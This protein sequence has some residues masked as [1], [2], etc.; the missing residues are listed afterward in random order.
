MAPKIRF[1]CYLLLITSKIYSQIPSGPGTPPSIPLVCTGGMLYRIATVEEDTIAAQTYYN[2]V[3]APAV[4][5][6]PTSG[7]VTYLTPSVFNITTS[8]VGVKMVNIGSK[9]Y[10]ANDNALYCYNTTTA[11][12]V[13]TYTPPSGYEIVDFSFKNDT[14]CILSQDQ[15]GPPPVCPNVDLV[16]KLN[17]S[18]IAQNLLNICLSGV[19]NY[20]L[21]A[22][23]T[24]A[25]VNNKLV[26]GGRFQAYNTSGLIDSNLVSFNLNTNL[27]Q[28]LNLKINDTV[29]EVE[30]KINQVHLVG[31]FTK[32]G[33][34]TRNH[35]AVLSNSLTL[36]AAPATSFVGDVDQIEFYDK[37]LFALGK[38]SQINSTV[39]NATPNYTIGAVNL[40]TNTVKN[41][42]INPPGG[43][44]T[45]SYLLKVIQNKL[46]V[47]C[48]RAGNTYARYFLPPRMAST[49]ISAATTS[50]CLPSSNN[51][52]SISPALYADSYSW[53]YS[54]TGVTLTFTN[55]IAKINFLTSATSGVLSVYAQ[56]TLGGI[57]DVLTLSL[58]A[59]PVPNITAS[60]PTQ[61][62]TCYNPKV[63]ILSSSTTTNVSFSWAG[64]SGYTSSNQN[65]S[66]GYN[67]PGKYV[68][69]V[70]NN[71]TGCK[72]R[73][74]VNVSIDTLRPNVTLPSSPV[75]L[76]C[77][78][79]SSQLNGSSSSPTPS[80]WWHL[81][82]S[83]LT[84][85]NPYYT[86]NVGNYYMV[87]KNNTNGCKDSSL[88]VVG[89][90]RVLPNLKIISHTYTSALVP[91]ETITCTNTLITV[92]GASDTANT[93][94]NWRDIASG[95]LSSNPINI[96]AQ[97]N[98][99][100]IVSRTDNGCVDSSLIVY[101]DQNITPP[102]LTI[103]TPS[104]NINCSSSTATLNAT[105]SFTNASLN[106]TGPSSFSSSNPAIVSNQGKYYV[107]AQRADNGCTKSDSVN[108][109]YSPVLI[110]QAGNDTTVCKNSVL[111]LTANASG[112]VTGITYIWNPGG[113]GQ[114]VNVNPTITTK[115]I[116]TANSA[117][118]C[119]GTDSILVTVPSDIRDSIVS[120]KNCSG[121]ALGSITIFASG[122]TPPYQYSFNGSA[123]TAQ[124]SYTNLPYGTYP[125]IIK[126]ALGC[127]VNTSGTLN[128]NSNM[129]TPVFI[130]ST[131]N[132]KGDTIVLIDLTVPKADSV[133]WT[134][135]GIASI[136]GGDMFNPLV[137]FTDTGNFAVTLTAFYAN[138]SI[139]T[140]KNIHV[141]PID[142]SLANATNNNGIKSIT[143]YPNPNTGIFTADIE[144]YKKQNASIMVIDG[145]SVKQYQQNFLNVD[146]ISL[147]VDLSNLS[148]GTYIFKV[149]G[150][151]NAKHL[152][153]IISK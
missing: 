114:N 22:Y 46:H 85:P 63:P 47:S 120:T 20:L 7:S 67:I 62:I 27:I 126:D 149:I 83:S 137:L 40:I 58:T 138:C 44:G 122:G 23:K 144:F 98:Y 151:Y 52:F 96:N 43:S 107:V 60:L 102:N 1:F 148:N 152:N 135:P 55:N 64:P 17:G 103:T 57:S 70:T 51:T 14:I 13:W 139:S 75:D 6:Q 49:A 123:F 10:Y 91:L 12:A 119:T 76:Y 108:V 125:I 45:N 37:Y 89:D 73:D 145:N 113:I 50:V 15:S 93:V 69:T 121:A 147:P 92:V 131:Q 84:H 61:S 78:P 34:A 21:G 33:L 41:F 29:K 86:K 97:G 140:T 35:Y 32:F 116:V 53:T 42:G 136:V 81:A 68:V 133:Q 111:S 95:T 130:A 128:Q 87:V 36:L 127:S 109:S 124:T 118:G 100:L 132:T 19:N 110:V 99:K 3:C 28:P 26:I 77:I 90:K 129:P 153:F 5:R 141:A 134:L 18:F 105:T 66:T 24:C 25:V 48:K 80:V 101:I 82:S 142:T 88:F 71:S 115:Y 56:S 74:S 11:N 104:A 112:T 146:F 59:F 94:I 16:N 39:I 117:G 143:L 31:S 79:D 54:G 65:D 106:W 9:I 38:F 4:E 8:G 72:N 2:I 30:F 150:E